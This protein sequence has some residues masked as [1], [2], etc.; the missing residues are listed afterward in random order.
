MEG[1]FAVNYNYDTGTFTIYNENDV[2]LAG[3]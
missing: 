3:F 1:E 2:S